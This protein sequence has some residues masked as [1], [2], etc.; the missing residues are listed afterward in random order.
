[1]K[2][3]H[4]IKGAA[5]TVAGASLI[6]LIPSSSEAVSRI[7]GANNRLSVGLIGVNGMGM[8]NLRR[9]LQNE[10][11]ECA[12]LCDVDRN[13]LDKRAAETAELQGKKPD[14]YGDYRKL[15]DRKDIDVV[16]S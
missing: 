13:V 8:S 7:P 6:P 3:R 5:T 4:F 16:I 10:S 2:R 14:L 15:L 9:F 1:M 11:V 12:A